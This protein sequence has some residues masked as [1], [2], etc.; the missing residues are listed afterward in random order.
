MKI[1]TLGIRLRSG[2]HVGIA[3]ASVVPL[4]TAAKQIRASGKHDGKEVLEGLVL[5]S[6]RPFPVF[7]FRCAASEPVKAV[8]SAKK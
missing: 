2:E 4:V 1:A 3:S 6:E 8:K 7:K 5:S